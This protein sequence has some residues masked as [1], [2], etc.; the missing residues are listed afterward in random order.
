MNTSKSSINILLVDKLLSKM[1]R[2]CI[3]CK[4]YIEYYGTICAN[5]L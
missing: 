5:K 2:I 3:I 1:D 4:K